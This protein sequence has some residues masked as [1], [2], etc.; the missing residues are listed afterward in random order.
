MIF[1]KG[2]GTLAYKNSITA[3]FDHPGR[4]EAVVRSQLLRTYTR[5]PGTSPSPSV[6][7]AR[8]TIR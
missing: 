5:T 3:A 6:G 4:R 2:G 1:G 8:S 7:A